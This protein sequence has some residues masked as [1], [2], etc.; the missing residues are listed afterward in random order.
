[1]KVS[2]VDFHDFIRVITKCKGKVMLITE[3]GNHINLASKLSQ[4]VG[5][6]NLIEKGDIEI[7]N[8][9]CELE[10]DYARI[11]RFLIYKEI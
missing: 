4:Y 10:E 7:A 5:I 11:I 6:F 1:M 2:N 3:E 8:I 9:Q